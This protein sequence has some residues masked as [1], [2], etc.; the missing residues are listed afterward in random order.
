MAATAAK[1]Q[2]E[3]HLPWFLTRETLLRDLQSI[4]LFTLTLNDTLF[5]FTLGQF[6]LVLPWEMC[7]EPWGNWLLYQFPDLPLFSE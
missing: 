2:Q 3:A 4:G 5:T 1:L 6:L 7:L